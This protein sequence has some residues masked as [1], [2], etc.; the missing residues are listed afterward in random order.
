MLCLRG[1]LGAACLSFISATLVGCQDY[2]FVHRETQRVDA[3]RVNQVVARLTPVDILFVIDNSPTMRE[4]TDALKNNVER[5]VTALAD[6]EVDFQIG[7]VTPDVECNSPVR[8]C[9]GAGAASYSCC[10]QNRPLCTDRDTNS[11]GVVDATDCELGRLQGTS[12]GGARVFRSPAPADKDQFV[13]NVVAAIQ[14]SLH[15]LV[16]SSFESGLQAASLAVACSVGDPVCSD[17]A[18]GNAAAA[19]AIN[20]GFI[21]DEA[22]LAVLFL[23]DEDDCSAA[24]PSVYQAPGN[25]SAPADQA[26]HFCSPDECYAYYNEG[27]DRDGNGLDDWSDPTPPNGLPA[28]R[29]LRC[30]QTG[31]IDRSVN[32]PKLASLD[33]F[34]TQL[35]NF[36][37]GNIGKVRAAGIISATQRAA[38]TAYQGAACIIGTNGPSDQ[39]GCT[40][41]ANNFSC[42]VTG[43]NGQS[44]VRSP[45]R[46]NSEGQVTPALSGCTTAPGNRYVQWLDMLGDE[47]E[48]AGY[49]RDV[50]VDSICR[51]T[52]DETLETI[53][54]NVIVSQCFDLE[55]VPSGPQ[56]LTVRLNGRDLPNVDA[57]SRTQGWSLRAGTATICLEGGLKKRVGDRYEI[58]QVTALTTP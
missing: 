19:R 41:G 28:D 20:A 29:R 14:F 4:E 24:S 15:G 16:G 13:Q 34:L 37:G 32:P 52:Y 8:V 40:A 38:N 27:T 26:T 46:A 48:A 56:F 10:A 31:T 9:S 43:A 3:Q 49:N 50:L 42:D 18:T 2:T 22:D 23:T 55:Q 39:C 21:R 12:A 6:Q 51:V 11:D 30:G 54:N 58:L 25:P 17:A 47:R 57:G 1:V 44:N 35:R 36:K 5:F 7:I 45:L 33:T 53:V